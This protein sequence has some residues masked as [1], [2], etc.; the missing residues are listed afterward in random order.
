M[1]TA[2]LFPMFLKLEGRNCLVTGA[3]SVGEQ[4]IRSL[5]DCGANVRVVDP[6]ASLAVREWANRGALVLLQRSFEPSDLDGAFLVVAATSSVE[7]NHAIYREA[8][9]RGILCNVVDDPPHCDFY[10]PAVVRRGQ[11]QIAIST[12]G[13]S[14]ALA[15]RIRKQLEDEFPPAYAGWLEDLDGKR[16]LLFSDGGDPELRR[17]LLH[18]LATPEAFVEFERGI[19]QFESGKEVL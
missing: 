13:L 5:L 17:R 9:A 15:Q 11:L 2:S 6:S 8:Q 16:E 4:K 7:V 14:P 1:N 19:N 3:G 10:Y 18:R 12:A